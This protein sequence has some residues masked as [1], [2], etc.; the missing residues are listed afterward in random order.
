[1]TGPSIIIREAGVARLS[2]LTIASNSASSLPLAHA[3]LDDRQLP[4]GC[5]L[6]LQKS[7]VA[8]AKF[9]QLISAQQVGINERCATDPTCMWCIALIHRQHSEPCPYARFSR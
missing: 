1:M 7:T 4:A 8:H 3:F 5:V 9:H 6:N 2:G